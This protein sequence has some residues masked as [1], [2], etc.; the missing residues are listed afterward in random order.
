M[1]IALSTLIRKSAGDVSS[2]IEY[3]RNDEALLATYELANQLPAIK[4]EF[5]SYMSEIGSLINTV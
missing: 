2:K 4:N 5:V 1:P 3:S